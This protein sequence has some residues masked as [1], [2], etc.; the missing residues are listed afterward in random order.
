MHQFVTFSTFTPAQ[1]ALSDILSNDSW[2]KEI[3][4]FYNQKR[5]LVTSLLQESPYLF[6][7]TRGSYFQT[8]SF[9]SVSS[10]SDVEFADHCTKHLGVTVIPLSPF[11]HDRR[12]TGSVRICF[13]K[14]DDTL[15]LG[16]DR[17]CKI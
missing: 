9:S 17:L 4:S 5:A 16:I 14:A 12:N 10:L 15:I 3:Q 2:Y 6:T 11:F 13:A 8:I 7:P 1:K